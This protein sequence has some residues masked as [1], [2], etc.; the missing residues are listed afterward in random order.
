MSMKSMRNGVGISPAGDEA[1]GGGRFFRP[2]LMLSLP[3]LGLALV[4]SASSS[5]KADGEAVRPVMQVTTVFATEPDDYR[6]DD[7]RAPVPATLKGGTVLSAH[8][9]LELWK[10]REAIFID[11]Y[12]HPPKPENLPKGTIWREPMHFSIENATWLANVGF[13]KLSKETDDYFR[14]HLAALTAGDK[15]RPVV[16]F[17]LRN[18]WMSWNAAKRAISYGYTRVLWFPDGTDA[19]QEIGQP[20]AQVKPMP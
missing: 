14:R 5:S 9:A 6:H 2:A 15:A 17:C 18:C 3:I 7:Y 20:V 19:W 16:F 12:P 11:T 13:G 1:S 4:L 8:E 10:K